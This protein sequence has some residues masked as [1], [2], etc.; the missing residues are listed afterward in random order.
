MA[1]F[2]IG[3]MVLCVALIALAVWAAIES[4]RQWKQFA[5][6]HQCRVIAKIRGDTINTMS[7]DSKGAP[8]IGIATT[9]DKTGWLCN[10]GI[11]YY[12]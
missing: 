9:P 7:F 2:M 1:R 3:T 12:R 6:E 8:V 11:T 5:A 10:D 4:G